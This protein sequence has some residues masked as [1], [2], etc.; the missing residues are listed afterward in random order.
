[1]AEVLA[2]T[3]PSV[4]AVTKRLA[5]VLRKAIDAAPFWVRGELSSVNDGG[6]R[7]YFDLVETQGGKAIAKLRCHLW[8]DAVATVRGRLQEARLAT[9][10]KNGMEVGVKIRVRFHAV[11]G[12]ALQVLDLDPEVILGDLAR[13]RREIVARLKKEDLLG[14]NSA[15]SIPLLPRR[16]GLVASFDTAGYADFVQTIQ[17]SGYAITLFHADARVQG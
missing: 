15:I 13:R 8:R 17:Q 2:H 12:L 6:N 5:D 7:I 10:L 1:M 16:V 3:Y 14:R 11:Y 9:T 4:S